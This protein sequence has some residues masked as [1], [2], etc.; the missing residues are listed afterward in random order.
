MSYPLSDKLEP[1]ALAAFDIG[2]QEN[3]TQYLPADPTRLLSL[4]IAISLKRIADALDGIET[5]LD[6]Q[7]GIT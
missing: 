2:P 5:T 7:A 4:S 6:I 3:P 1:S